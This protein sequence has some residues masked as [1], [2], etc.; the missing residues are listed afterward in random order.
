MCHSRIKVWPVK[1]GASH[2]VCKNTKL[3]QRLADSSAVFWLWSWKVFSRTCMIWVPMP[4]RIAR[5]EAQKT[6]LPGVHYS[7]ETEPSHKCADT[8]FQMITDQQITWIPWECLTT[9][10]HLKQSIVRR[11]CRS[12]S[13]LP[14]RSSCQ[15][16]RTTRW[17]PFQ[18]RF[19]CGKLCNAVQEPLT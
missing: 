10:E 14:V 15:K 9:I 4:E 11:T 18:V 17:A 16:P 5:L 12:L 8:V 6:Q 13:M 7:S 2:F 3:F 1:G 19:R